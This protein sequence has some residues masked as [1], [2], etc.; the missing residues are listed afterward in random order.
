MIFDE[1]W[2]AERTAKKERKRLK[3]KYGPPLEAAKKAKRRE[4]KLLAKAQSAETR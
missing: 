1:L 3:D 4:R 2:R